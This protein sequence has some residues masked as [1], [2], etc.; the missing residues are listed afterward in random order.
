MKTTLTRREFLK[1]SL[2]GAGLTIAVSITPFGT[3][4]LSAAEVE[5]EKGLFS[6]NVWIQITPEDLVYIV[7]NKS[8]MG[9]G[10]YT[11]L[12]M[13]AA[14]ELDADW[15][16]VRLEVAPADEKYNDPAWG[17][18][19]TGGSTS[20]WHM[21]EPL[22]KA[23]AAA[24]EML[25]RAAAETWNVPVGECEA[26][27]GT[28]G[29]EGSKRKISYGKLALKA[30]KLSVP[31]N[32]VLKKESKFTLMGKP[33]SRLDI[34][35]KVH[36]KAKFGIDTFVP[37]MLY[38]AVERPPAYGAK[39]VSF[40]EAAAMKIKGTLK[41]LELP[42]G[43]AACAEFP[44]QAWRAIEALKVKWDR[45]VEPDLSNETLDRDFTAALSRKGAIARQA[46]DVGAALGKAVKKKQM[47]YHLPYLCHV[48]M[49]PMNCTADVRSDGCEIWVPTQF[50]TATLQFAQKETGLKPDQIKV[51]TTYLGGGYGRRA[52]IDIVE[53]AVRIS[54]AAGKPVKVIWRREEDVKHDF[55]RPQTA[56]RIE[57]GLDEKGRLIAWSHK[58]VC[59]SIFARAFPA[60]LKGDIDP[61]AI[62]CLE[63]L[64][65]EVPNLSVEYV[66]IDKPVPVGFWRSVGASH[67]GFTVE[68]FVD[69]M[70]H[71]A[72][73]DPLEFRLEHLKEHPRATRVL[74]TVAEKAGWGKPIRNGEG[75][76]IAWTLAFGTYA[77]QVAEV[78]VD[79]KDGTIKVRRVVCAIDCGP[80]VNP[81]TITAQVKGAIIMGISTALKEKVKFSKGG[82]SSSNFSDYKT[83]RMSEAPEELEVHIIKSKDKQSGVGE[84][85][86][87]PSAPAVANA[88]FNTTGVRLRNLPMTTEDVRKAMGKA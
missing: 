47:E 44:E 40:D 26:S 50:Q 28:V 29:H 13:I 75:R 45:G 68:S 72:G 27:K 18:Q 5:K 57:G 78:S 46:G 34:P 33:M 2:A 16:K 80:I 64:E 38:A 20:V 9:Q 22:R 52:E 14:D 19:L 70:A 66:R 21:Y 42:Q 23:G 43:V 74:Q 59:P 81:A 61:A 7:V 53:D 87:P 56:T 51:H 12:P 73:K 3:R 71:L 62:D 55:Y 54:K 10:V 36:A 79:R 11:S 1:K 35:D 84:P 17:R 63:D 88:V 41:I 4:I 48:A 58:V 65:Y 39:P 83:L 31:Q 25:L 82:V 85:G 6:P 76:G 30:A 69:E 67:N 15:S 8:E 24:R 32:P 37:G 86:L 77:A 49:E 60:R